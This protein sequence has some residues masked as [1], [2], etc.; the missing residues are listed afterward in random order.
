MAITVKYLEELGIEKE[1]AEK[2]FAERSKEI[3]SEKS[4]L[5][6]LQNKLSEKETSYNSLTEE[7]EK[8]KNDNATAEDFKT[9]FETLQNEIKEKEEKAEA[10]RLAKEK[11]DGIANRFNTVSGEKEWNHD[12]IK[13][14][15]L[16][17]F[18]EALENKDFEG[19]SDADIFHELTKNDATAFKGVTAFRLEGGATRNIGSETDDAKAR[20][21][22][23][24]P[25]LK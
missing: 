5:T 4:K 21:V 11:A 10:D 9:K 17:K 8:L 3:E 24:L 25:P 14:D 20:A 15:Y 13:A 22:M 16:K 1:T 2:I 23:G 18:G 7:L 6:E 19:K 12:A